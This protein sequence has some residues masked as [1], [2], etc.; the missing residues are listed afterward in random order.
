M[1]F[2]LSISLNLPLLNKYVKGT[3][4]KRQ[5]NFYWQI[6]VLWS[7]NFVLFSKDKLQNLPHQN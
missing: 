4:E 2:L 6:L 1:K 3:V 7:R 5:K